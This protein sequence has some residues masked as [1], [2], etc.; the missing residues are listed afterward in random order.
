[1]KPS[2]SCIKYA[3][4]FTLL[5]TATLAFTISA[6]CTETE[7]QSVAVSAA[8]ETKTPQSASTCSSGSAAQ[9]FSDQEFA[10]QFL[11]TIGASY[12]GEADIGEC[13]K[14]ASRID[15]G[16]F[17]SWYSEWKKT[18]DAIRNIGDESLR[19]GHNRTAMNAYYRAA[20]YYRTAEFFLHGNSTDSRIVETWE[21][22]RET[23]RDA[24]A[25]D[26]VSYEIVSIPYENTTLP[27]YF[28]KAD[29]S[30]TPHPLLIVQT[31][32]DGCQEELHT[33]VNEGIK[34]GYNVLTFEGP[35]QGEVIRIQHIP[36]RY[37]WENV[38]TPVVDYAVSRPDVDENRIALWGISLGGYLAP[39][40][41]AYESR[42]AALIADPGTYDVGENLLRNLQEEGADANM[43]KEDLKEWLQTD[44]AE[45]NDAIRDAMAESTGTRWMNENGM[46]VFNAGSPA[47]F[48]AKWM[49]FSLAGIAGEIRCP[50]LVCAGEA[51]SLDK[52]A[53]QAKELYDSL[54]CEKEF[55]LFQDEYGAGSHCQFGAFGQSFGAKFDWLDDKIGINQ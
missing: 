49:D 37:D 1:M 10:F 29:N 31:G 47:Q 14:T 39:R 9:I 55:I 25:L 17:E 22:S 4:T 46:F 2:K 30:G 6:G 32:F 24:L 18:A 53:I 34:R 7:L 8:T 26:D 51:D 28:Y 44:P 23:F 41:A 52:D 15:E 27:G 11:R 16:D 40:G 20:T 38:I 3:I 33:Y 21:K 19:E 35:G 50:T 13:L 5:V 43:T 36:F 45:F 54:A 12:S 42:I 48:W